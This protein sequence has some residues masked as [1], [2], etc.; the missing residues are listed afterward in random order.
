MD[1]KERHVTAL[2]LVQHKLAV[3]LQLIYHLL[4]VNHLGDGIGLLAPTVALVFHEA[5]KSVAA[6]NTP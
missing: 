5:F 3:I 6:E 1:R 2:F 4:H